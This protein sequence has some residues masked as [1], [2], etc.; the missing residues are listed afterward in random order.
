MGT[1]QQHLVIILL[2]FSWG[3]V[4]VSALV[5]HRCVAITTSLVLKN[6]HFCGSGTQAWL[7]GASAQSQQDVTQ[8]TAGLLPTGGPDGGGRGSKL[9]WGVG[10][11]CLL[12]ATGLRRL[13][14]VAQTAERLPTM[15]E[16]RVRSLVGENPLEKG[17]ETHSSIFALRILWTEEP[18][19]LQSVGSQ[20]VGHD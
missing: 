19:G 5:F 17:M 8:V 14:L 6:D 18:G 12:G 11:T 3:G 10:R 1:E 9:T 15:W 2:D 13:S 20:R 7:S 4:A 16:T